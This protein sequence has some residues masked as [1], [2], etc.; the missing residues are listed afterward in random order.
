MTQT[1]NETQGQRAVRWQPKRRCPATLS[2]GSP[3]RS[4]GCSPT[5]PNQ[6]ALTIPWRGQGRA[7]SGLDLWARVLVS[8]PPQQYL[9]LLLIFHFSWYDSDL[10]QLSF[11]SRSSA[12]V[13]AHTATRAA[14]SVVRRCLSSSRAIGDCPL[15]PQKSWPLGADILPCNVPQLQP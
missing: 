1:C 10:L 6:D 13:P 8:T 3:L 9:D 12:R 14:H 7:A 4:V 2:K 5:D 15:Y 11:A